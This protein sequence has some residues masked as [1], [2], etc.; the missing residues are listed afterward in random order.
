[1]DQLFG[2]IQWNQAFLEG[3]I[4][5]ALLGFGRLILTIGQI[6]HARSEKKYLQFIGINVISISLFALI[7]GIMTYATEGRAGNI[8]SGIAALALLSLLA[9]DLVPNVKDETVE[10]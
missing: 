6:S 4:G 1:M 5:G 3:G 2:W 7:G 10:G 9:G 8:F